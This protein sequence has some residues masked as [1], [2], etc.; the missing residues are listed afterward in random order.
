MDGQAK[1][2]TAVGHEIASLKQLVDNLEKENG[3]LRDFCIEQH[4]KL[5]ALENRTGWDKFN[6]SLLT[7]AEHRIDD[8]ISKLVKQRHLRDARTDTL[9]RDGGF[10]ID[11][12][13]E[14]KRHST[15]PG[16]T[17]HSEIKE[18]RR[19]IR[20]MDSVVALAGRFISL[21]KRK[22]KA[23]NDDIAES[24]D[25][26]AKE[27]A[28]GGMAEWEERER[29][30]EEHEKRLVDEQKV[31]PHA[32]KP[33]WE[34]I[35]AGEHEQMENWKLEKAQK[36]YKKSIENEKPTFPI[37]KVSTRTVNGR[38]DTGKE[39]KEVEE[40]LVVAMEKEFLASFPGK[41]SVRTVNW[42]E[43]SRIT[44]SIFEVPQPAPLASQ[45][46]LLPIIPTQ[47]G[48]PPGVSTQALSA[49][50]LPQ[51]THPA[52][53]TPHKSRPRQTHPPPP[54]PALETDDVFRFSRPATPPGQATP[55]AENLQ[56]LRHRRSAPSPTP[57]FVSHRP[58]SPS[59]GGNEP[60]PP[61]PMPGWLMTRKG[62]RRD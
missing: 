5:T 14:K 13:T 45:A 3:W 30:D 16:S 26:E 9:E 19:A 49:Q 51:Q 23:K 32:L 33:M 40:E 46:P 4:K 42:P 52:P 10:Q 28:K 22:R 6:D 62:E 1:P 48:L 43:G 44:G 35:I 58:A 50:P 24:V 27:R 54:P 60:M 37:R 34:K 31:C 29:L 41:D 17:S 18:R 47:S 8:A 55:L 25:E 38:Q 21:F 57:R 53:A 11:A 61:N 15:L 56:R 12:Q 7:L 20:R 36:E 2:I 39:S 59:P